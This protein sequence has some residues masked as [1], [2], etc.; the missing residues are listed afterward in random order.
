MGQSVHLR[1]LLRRHT[2]GPT[3]P[4]ARKI[5]P[6]EPTRANPA[7]SFTHSS[8]GNH[9]SAHLVMTVFSRKFAT[10]SNAQATAK[11]AEPIAP[12]RKCK[13]GD[14]YP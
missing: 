1:C 4:G 7:Y 11:I 2:D 6:T 12:V 14:V 10:A 8:A 5:F 3:K 13:T 9:D